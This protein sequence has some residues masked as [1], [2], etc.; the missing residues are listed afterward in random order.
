MRLEVEAATRGC[1]PSSS[2]SGDTIMP[3]PMP[4]NPAAQGPSSH[5]AEVVA[6]DRRQPLAEGTRSSTS[7]VCRQHSCNGAC[8][9]LNLDLTGNAA[10][11]QHDD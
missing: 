9:R 8:S 10:A 3:P 7:T 2:S 1:T 11:D 4:S 5:L 6:I